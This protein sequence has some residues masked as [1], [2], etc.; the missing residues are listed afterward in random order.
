MSL[1]LEPLD[2]GDLEGY[3]RYI[4]E[5][6]AREKAESGQWAASD[7]LRRSEKEVASLLTDGV[8]SEGHFIY[9]IWAGSDDIG[10]VWLH[11]REEAGRTLAWIYDFVVRA[12]FRGKGFGS[13]AMSAAE[14]KA[15]EL[16]ADEM[17]LHGR[18]EKRPD[19]S[20]RG[21]NPFALG[22]T[23]RLWRVPCRGG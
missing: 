18:K 2:C 12:E 9:S 17:G 22:I 11:I 16:G 15:K 21:A 3:R 1:G 13:R 23:R 8:D 10:R 20:G 4:V 5:N 6:Y 14:A 7:S 19:F